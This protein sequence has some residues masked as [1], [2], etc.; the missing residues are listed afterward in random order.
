ME[1][2]FLCI[3]LKTFYASVECVERHLDPFNTNLVVADPSRGRGAICL[4]VTPKMN[5]LGVK[6]RC[7]IYEIPPN[8]KYIVALPRMKK[9]IEYSANIYAIYL[10]YFSKDDIHVYSIDEAFIDVTKYLKLYKVT[11]V[12]LAKIVINN[13]FNKYG[14]TATAGVG[15]NLYLAKVALD[16][17]AK[18]SVTNIG[19]LNEEK[20]K[21]EL[22]HHRP[23][24]DF[25]QIGN[26]I[27]KRLNKLRI[28]D[29]YDIAHTEPKRLYKEF[30]VN[31]EYII[32]H[33]FGRESCTIEDIKRYNPKSNS[34]SNSQ[35]LFEDYSFEKARIVLKE[36]VELGS[37][38]L[39][40]QNLSTNKIK[41]YVGYSKDII[42]STGGTERIINYTNVY[43]ELLKP[44]LK[45][46]DE[47][48]NRNVG[49][50]RIGISFDN[51]LETNNVQL[52]LF[53]DQT[54]IDKEKKLEL[55]INNIK[56]KM[57]KNKV[58]RGID[59]QEGATAIIRNQLIGGHNS[60]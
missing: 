32:D 31:A 58:L 50:R 54:K 21:K 10:K 46:Y 13:I 17:T 35:V 41:L 44:F 23:L 51:V 43:S 12:E 57:G 19:F 25:W 38:R 5:M 22:W 52:T 48:T 8:I 27:E 55:T 42:K 20:Y 18:H 26:G 39:I 2:S 1:K 53:K 30:G 29:M 15:T 6:N 16:I 14:I 45:I 37:L 40:E 34:L 3:D 59:L 47:S 7:R 60:G 36:M 4:A 24:K 28:F 49:I 56:N 11:A 33:A 9:Y